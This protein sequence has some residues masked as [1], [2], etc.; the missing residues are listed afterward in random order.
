M[1]T[2]L[3]IT[4]PTLIIDEKKC[5]TKIAAMQKKAVYNGIVFRPHF[6]THQSAAIGEWF[7]QAGVSSIAVSSV[8]M[9]CYFAQHRWHDIMIAIPINILEIDAI[10]SLAKN[11]N[12]SIVLESAELAMRLQKKLKE[13]VSVFIEIDIGD[14]RT[15]IS[16]TNI[17]EIQHLVAVV[18][19]HQHTMFKGF[20]AHAG[21][22]YS[23]RGVQQI[24]AIHEASEQKLKIIQ[25]CFPNAYLSIG[26][27]PSCSI[28]N[29]FSVI[30]EIRPGNFIF[31]DL[32]QQQIGACNFSDI[33]CAI[34]CPII[35]K[36]PQRNEIVIYGGGVHLSK[37]SIV[38]H[39]FGE[40]FGLACTK[41]FTPL[42]NT[43]VKKLSQEH[44][45]VHL[46]TAFFN[47]YH[48]GDLLYILPIH[49]C[50]A[51][52]LMSYYLTS[53]GKKVEKY[54]Y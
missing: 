17:K 54:N 38:H 28:V 42:E 43:Y 20:L 33:S 23:A 5:R 49:S 19:Q 12:L 30:N 7:R 4:R 39:Q 35:A 27:T 46:P 16:H 53:S 34:A 11:I 8:G 40:I 1:T 3:A 18:Q 48:I 13:S 41:N 37:D 45:V 32:M 22:T 44:G 51:A 31:Y 47:Q 10:N 36:Y 50:M 2:N 24:K 15:G 26:D 29:T 9:A 21:H 25:T 14:N 52:D 6:K